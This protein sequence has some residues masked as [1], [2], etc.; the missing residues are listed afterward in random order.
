M[1]S[2]LKNVRLIQGHI[3]SIESNVLARKLILD[4]KNSTGPAIRDLYVELGLLPMS[5]LIVQNWKKSYGNFSFEL[6]TV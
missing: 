2:D 4:S 3:S 6:T 1:S 5:Q